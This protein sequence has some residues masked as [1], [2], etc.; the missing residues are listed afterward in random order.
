M[1]LIYIF[2]ATTCIVC[3][4]A[5]NDTM[6]QFV[7]APSL[8][9][10][11]IPSSVLTIALYGWNNVRYAFSI[12]IP[13]NVDNPDLLYRTASSFGI[14]CL[15]FGLL[16]MLIG[17][18]KIFAYLDIEN[19]MHIG[20]AAGVMLLPPTYGL[21]IHTLFAKPFAERWK[22]LESTEYILFKSH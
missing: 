22:I 8:C 3:G 16:S 15:W 4:M 12:S 9:I 21:C 7:D 11:L 13:D 10:V 18:V 6:P 2:I 20:P 17:A 5:Y 19:L 14:N 1:F